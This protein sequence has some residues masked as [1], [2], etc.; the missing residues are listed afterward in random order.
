MLQT[1][2]DKKTKP[3]NCPKILTWAMCYF[4]ETRNYSKLTV[5]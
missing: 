1:I 5:K 2:M 3:Q 4:L